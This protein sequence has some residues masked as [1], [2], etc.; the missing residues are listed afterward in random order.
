MTFV[1]EKTVKS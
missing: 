1:Q